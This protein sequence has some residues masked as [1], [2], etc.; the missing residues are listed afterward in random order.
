MVRKLNLGAIVGIIAGIVIIVMAVVFLN[1]GSNSVRTSRLSESDLAK[2]SQF[3]ISYSF[4]AD[5]YTEMFGVTYKT[6]EQLN[7]MSQD[8]AR[9]IARSTN[10]LAASVDS[11]VHMLAYLMLAIGIGVVG[12]SCCKLFLWVPAG[13]PK[14]AYAPAPDYFPSAPPADE[15]TD[16]PAEE[17]EAGEEES[18]AAAE[19]PEAG[20]EEPEA[21]DAAE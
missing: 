14:P 16:E 2:S 1:G 13:S 17:P 19:E 9:N 18:V 15:K 8:N 3:Q 6:L 7:D 12:L 21:A 5:F 11:V 4:G 10:T 20:E